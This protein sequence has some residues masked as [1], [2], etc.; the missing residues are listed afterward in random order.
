MST[1]SVATAKNKLSE[2]IKR[3][4]AGED[5]VITRHGQPVVE[6][7]PVK[8]IPGPMMEADWAWLDANRVARLDPEKDAVDLVRELR[9]EGEA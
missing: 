4:I 6:L 1:Y 5:V 7:R 2:L 3:A 9:D 8:R